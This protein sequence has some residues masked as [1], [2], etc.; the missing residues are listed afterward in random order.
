MKRGPRPWPDAVGVTAA[1]PGP[2]LRESHTFNVWPTGAIR[3][4]SGLNAMAISCP[5]SA[6]RDSERTGHLLGGLPRDHLPLAIGRRRRR[7]EG[8]TA[9][10]RRAGRRPYAV[11]RSV[12]ILSLMDAAIRCSQLIKT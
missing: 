11:G 8:R 5:S 7:R 6:D 9:A 12:A 10:A 1:V 3:E 2:C 4:L